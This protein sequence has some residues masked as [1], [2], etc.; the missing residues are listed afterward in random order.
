MLKDGDAPLR[1]NKFIANS[2]VCVR[3]EAD[4]S[5]PQAP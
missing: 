2:G 3:R 1:L 5:S 4:C